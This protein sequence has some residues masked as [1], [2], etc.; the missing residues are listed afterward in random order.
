MDFERDIQHTSCPNSHRN[1]IDSSMPS[2]QVYQSVTAT[3][4]AT[5]EANKHPL[6]LPDIKKSK[7]KNESSAGGVVGDSAP[8]ASRQ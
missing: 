1:L 6:V 2:N 4:A 8:I 7:S 3:A 5:S